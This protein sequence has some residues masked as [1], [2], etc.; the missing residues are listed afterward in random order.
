MS[1][2]RYYA[3]NEGW[4]FAVAYAMLAVFCALHAVVQKVTG[5]M[6]AEVVMDNGVGA[7][8]TGALRGACLC[9]FMG[10]ASPAVGRCIMP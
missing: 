6:C 10:H 7:G 5:K 9:A 2:K 4:R 3:F 1:T 8:P